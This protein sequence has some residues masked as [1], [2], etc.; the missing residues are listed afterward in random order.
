MVSNFMFFSFKGWADDGA[1]ECLPNQPEPRQYYFP[2]Q[3]PKHSGLLV[4]KYTY[5][6]LLKDN[7]PEEV[8]GG[9][10]EMQNY[11]NSH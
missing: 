2:D 3:I 6:I 1:K 10:F 5:I 8:L 11:K 9:I 7:A 4:K